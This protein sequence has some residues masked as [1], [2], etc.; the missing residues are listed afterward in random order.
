M[1]ERAAIEGRFC[2]DIS[3]INCGEKIAQSWE[4]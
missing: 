3:R 2:L 4:E 1:G